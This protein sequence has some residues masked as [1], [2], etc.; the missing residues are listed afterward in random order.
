VVVIAGSLAVTAVFAWLAFLL[1]AWGF[2]TR[3]YF[4]HDQ[5]LKA[6]VKKKPHLDQ[7]VQ[8]LNEEGTP[9]VAA[10]GS[11]SELAALVGEKGGG[12]AAESLDKA[13]RWKQIRVFRATGLLY[14]L[15]FD[16]A[17]TLRDFALVPA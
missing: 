12:R 16:E 2:E 5:R 1:G 6:L 14:V 13:R 7:V 8:A 10:P 4:Q 15:Y 17:G 3:N 11:E 9:L